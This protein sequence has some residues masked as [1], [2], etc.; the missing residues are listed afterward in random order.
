MLNLLFEVDAN[1]ERG[2]LG[3]KLTDFESAVSSNVVC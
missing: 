3:S 2:K 1:G